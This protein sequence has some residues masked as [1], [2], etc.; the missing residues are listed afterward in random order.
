[1]VRSAKKKSTKKNRLGIEN[2]LVNNIQ[3]QEE[4]GD[5]RKQEKIYDRERIV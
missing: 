1:M 5:F 4:K 3:C 2:S